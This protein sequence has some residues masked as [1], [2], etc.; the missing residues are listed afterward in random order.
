MDLTLPA[1]ASELRQAADRFREEVLVPA[2]PLL[3]PAEGPL[4]SGLEAESAR[5]RR[6]LGLWGMSVPQALGGRGLGWLS[7]VLVQ[8]RL[9]RSP[10]GMWGYGLSAAGEPPAPLW[11]ATGTQRERFLAPCL[12]GRTIAHQ[13][14]LPA[15][16]AQGSS[17]TATPS[18][19]AIVL[20]GARTAVPAFQTEGLLVVVAW[21]QG[22]RLALVCDRDLE[23]YRI[24]HR[25]PGMGAVELVD[26]RWEGCRVG[27]DRTLPDAGPAADA[28]QARQRVGAIAAGALGAAAFC[29]ELGLEHARRRQTFGRPLADRQAIQWMLADAARDLHGARLLVYRAAQLADGGQ[30]ADA[31]ELAGPAKAHATD[32]ACR[33][34]DRMLQIHGGYGYT[35]DLPLERF[36]RELRFYRF[37]EGDNDAILASAAGGLLTALDA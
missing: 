10:V 1:S 30:L 23:G 20:D 34:V 6:E 25:R 27:P 7:Q 32:V 21:M 22:Q 5:R 9:Q 24:E 16:G 19:D 2:E 28:W 14:V 3:P 17:P 31:V 33:I 8:E 37:A 36:W 29:V 4:P 13:L 11:A 35:R 18:G 15:P 26:I 12:A